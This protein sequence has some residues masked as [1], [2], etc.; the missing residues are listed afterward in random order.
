MP[1]S[2]ITPSAVTAQNVDRQPNC[3]PS[4]VP[5]GTPSTFATVSPVNMSAIALACLA[6][7]TSEDA[8]LWWLA[9]MPDAPWVRPDDWVER[10]A[11][12]FADRITAP[13]LLLHAELDQNVNIAHSERLYA[14]LRVLGRSVEFVR[15]PG[16]G[17]L[18]DLV[19]SAR[20]RVAR[21]ERIAEFLGRHL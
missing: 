17:H 20:F 14:A 21:M 9:E 1:S 12:R 5:P 11:F 8:G 13:L 15:V 3:W 10:S 7:G 18:M 4:A 2:P 19:G 6:F 16:E